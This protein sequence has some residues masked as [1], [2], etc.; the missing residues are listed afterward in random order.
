MK[1]KTYITKNE[2][3][4]MNLARRLAGGLKKGD[5][6]GLIGELGSG[7]TVFAKGIAR[8]LGIREKVTSPT[9]TLLHAYSGKKRLYHFDLYRLNCAEELSQIG[10][11][12]Y[13]WGDGVV[14][15]EWAD[16]FPDL[17]PGRSTRIYFKTGKKNIRNIRIEK[18]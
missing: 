15:V 11:E 4:T 16:K 17:L 8:G 6:L 18:P 5:V 2:K 10:Y 9:F 7:K 13:F 12:E 1:Q 14:L 3:E